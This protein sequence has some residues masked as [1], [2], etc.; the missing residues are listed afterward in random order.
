MHLCHISPRD[1]VGDPFFALGLSKRQ[2]A[3]YKVTLVAWSPKVRKPEKE[4]LGENLVCLRLPGFNLG[5]RPWVTEYPYIPRLG[6]YIELI[7]PTILHVHSHLFLT[8]YQAYKA[9]SRLGIPYVVTVH[10]FRVRRGAFV[11]LAQTAYLKTL[12]RRILRGA[13]FVI[14]LTRSDA[15]RVSKL[16]SLSPEKIRVVPVPVDLT[17]FASGG[18][19]LPGLVVWYGRFVKEKGLE[20]LIRAAKILSNE[21][22]LDFRLLLV[23]RGPRRRFIENLVREEAL[24]GLITVRDAVPHER[25]PSILSRAEVFVLPSLS[26]GMPRAL[27]EAMA[28]GKAVVASSLPGVR[29]VV[30]NG[31]NGLLVPPGDPLRLAEALSILLRDSNLRKRIGE[32]ARLAVEKNFSWDRVLRDLDAI[33]REALAVF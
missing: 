24:E 15:E 22:G 32:S 5:L 29:E 3:R 28:A 6:E 7:S 16:A 20:V 4:Q 17:M 31:K 18:R 25:I 30:I 27:L 11:D 23:G 13:K 14:C 10:G 8:S 2:S 9:A 21:K 26:E 19:P 12:G 1:T 33:Y